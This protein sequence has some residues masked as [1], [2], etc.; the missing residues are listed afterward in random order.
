MS[1]IDIF[2][3]ILLTIVLGSIL[4]LETETREIEKEGL[5]KAEKDEKQKIGGVRTY[6]VI[7][8]FGGVA[9]LFF[10]AG[11]NIIAYLLFLTII[12]LIVSAYILNVELK[13][14][15]GMTTEIAV[16]ITFTLGF[17]TT[18]NLIP[19]SSILAI[20]IFLSF[21]LSQKRGIGSL[22][23]KIQ[24]KEVIDM[25]TFGLIS[26][27]I[28]P[29]LPNQTYY[30]NDFLNSVNFNLLSNTSVHNFA[31]LNPFQIWLLVVLVSGLNLFGYILSKFTGKSKGLYLAGVFWGLVSSTSVTISIAQKARKE[32][33]GYSDIYASIILVSN[34]V[35]FVEILFTTYIIGVELFFKVVP[36]VF[37]LFVT[38]VIASLFFTFRQRL[39]N[40][41]HEDIDDL[42]INYE[43]F[44]LMPALKFVGLILGI[45]IIIQL[46]KIL[47]PSAV[48]I[49]L[50]SL[51]GV[52]GLTPGTIVIGNLL[53]F[54]NV[55]LKLAVLAFIL[56]NFVNFIAKI[57]YSYKLGNKELG[58]RILVGLSF[59]AIVI[60]IYYIL[61]I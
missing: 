42:N 28:L 56:L 61:V 6:T 55:S 27:V 30:L 8:L 33:K 9:G 49:F 18:S 53:S 22:I 46:I 23:Q 38:G 41:K 24:H 17:L 20:L 43:P 10:S 39:K 58:N 11:Q 32:K 7:S 16:V 36:I 2:I 52:I 59:S 13:K 44:S 48:S 40:I 47:L 45:Q 26:L 54:G 51:T 34:A 14:A 35:S 15:F 29:L 50:V 60:L 57:I 21:F 31:I 19:L 37:L 5:D 25:I 12:L 4:G 1:Q 3:K